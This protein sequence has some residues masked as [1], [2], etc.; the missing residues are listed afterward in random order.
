MSAALEAKSQQPEAPVR[1][2][3]RDSL[4]I[5]RR[6]L[7]HLAQLP[8]QLI[9]NLVFP[10]LLVLMFGFVFGS[11]MT[12]P[13]GGNYRAFLMPGMFVMAMVLAMAPIVL[14]VATDGTRGVTDRFRT[15]PMSRFAVVTG[16][17]F[18]DLATS[19]L[20]LLVL[21]VC[22][23]AIG[24]RANGAWWQTLGALG[25]LLLLRYALAWVGIYLGLVLRSPEL[26]GVAL[27]GIYPLAMISNTFVVPAQMP[28]WLGFVAEWNPLSATV[29]ALRE[30]FGNPGI[31][32]GS[33]WA[34]EHALG[35]AV[36]WPALLVAVFLPLAVARYRRA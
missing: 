9:G 36:A 30:L 3:I 29:T 13:G 34:S 20:D 15:L 12:I 28:A 33:S 24:W 25:L 35:L 27:A 21:I 26:A 14:S 18:A 32:T 10:V 16:R 4:V 19:L 7:T 6:H 17:S 8:A 31:A 11:A 22:G 2:A 1:W 5:T 23:L